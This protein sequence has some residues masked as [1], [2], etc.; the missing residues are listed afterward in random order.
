MLLHTAP[1]LL[2]PHCGVPRW[3]LACCPESPRNMV[4]RVGTCLLSSPD[5]SWPIADFGP[6]GTGLSP[7]CLA[8]GLPATHTYFLNRK[9]PQAQC[10]LDLG[11]DQPA[12]G[13]VALAKLGSGSVPT[14]LPGKLI[15]GLPPIC[16]AAEGRKPALSS[17]WRNR[18]LCGDSIHSPHV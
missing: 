3:Q 5:S 1:R 13:S 15:S 4:F 10:Q 18:G 9:H 11:Q 12:S 17:Y 7:G 6:Q 8:D 2:Q 16:L 14:N